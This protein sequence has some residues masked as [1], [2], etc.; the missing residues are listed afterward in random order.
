MSN[1]ANPPSQQPVNCEPA[2]EPGRRAAT[3]GRSVSAAATVSPLPVDTTRTTT[4]S[5]PADSAL[6]A[7]DQHLYPA[8]RMEAV[9]SPVRTASVNSGII[10]YRKP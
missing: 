10:E 5:S 7:R 1:N 3:I 2:D 8:A 4:T 9:V 6:I